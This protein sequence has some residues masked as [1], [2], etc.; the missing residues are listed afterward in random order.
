M[1][2]KT[3]IIGYGLLLI[4]LIIGLWL[5]IYKLGEI[6]QGFNWDEAANGYNAYSLLKT[7]RDEF[8]QK[9]PIMM[10]SFGEYKTG[11]GS[12]ILVPVIKVLGL[13]VFSV[14]LPNAILGSFLILVVFYL[15]LQ[16]FKQL[17][18][19]SL[20]AGLIAISPW[21]IH[22]SRF[23][24]EWYL[25]IPLMIFGISLLIDESK[26]KFRLP[27][28]AVLLASSLYFYASIKLVLPLLLLTYIIIYHQE[29]RRNIK[30]IL[31]GIFLG[32]LT[33][34][35][36]LISM[37]NNNWLTR[38][39]KV[40]FFNEDKVNAISE[41]INQGF[42]RYSVTNLP[43][44]LIRVFNNKIIFYGQEIIDKYFQFYSADFLLLGKEPSPMLAIP[45]VG[46]IYLISLPFLIL[47]IFTAI[48]NKTKADKLLIAWLLF[49]PIPSILT[50]DSPHSLRAIL[51]LPVLEIFVVKGL[52]YCYEVIRHKNY[53]IKLFFLST[54][55]L[56]YAVSL[57][58]FLWQYFFF[59][60]EDRAEFW[61]D[62]YKEA[63][64]KTN[65]YK[66]NYDKVIF[67]TDKGQPHIFFAFFTPIEPNDYQHQIVNQQNIF[68]AFVPY[69]NK[70]EFRM[71]KD[72]DFCIKNAL[73]IDIPG[74]KEW[75]ERLD[76]VYIKN[77][78]HPPKKAF[79]LFD[80]NN[81]SVQKYLCPGK[82]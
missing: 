34:L 46:K 41:E 60:P 7:G 12:M 25:G 64:E 8:G 4:F 77:R 1:I 17:I 82:S 61:L 81:P 59:Y 39:Q 63:V 79:E 3:N 62:G 5:R 11:V 73:I 26:N 24:L 69:L 80:T 21:A 71:I 57:C 58:F 76:I 50:T 16:I 40:N 72:E 43:R 36:L 13:S 19:A 38:A 48:K 53:W 31:I 35:P 45:K 2:K 28:A 49:A 75:R 33:L 42:Y 78:F 37:K 14:R 52:F 10:K 29:L 18:P 15:S 70:V 74:R 66:Q 44:Q 9:W 32:T 23:A 56:I 65:K 67:T 68:N 54:M 22:T 51:L 6:P 47:G 30:G 55:S 20:T 27:L